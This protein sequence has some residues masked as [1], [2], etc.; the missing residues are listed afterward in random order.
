[1]KAEIKLDINKYIKSYFDLI[2]RCGLNVQPKQKVLISAPVESANLALMAAQAAYDAGAGRVI[3][4]WESRDISRLGFLYTDPE[5][6]ERADPWDKAQLVTLAKEGAAFLFLHSANPEVFSDVNPDVIVKQRRV[7]NASVK[8]WRDRYMSNK[9][10]WCVAAIA[11]ASWARKVF[12][13]LPEEEAIIELWDAIFKAARISVDSSDE[14]LNENLNENLFQNLIENS[15]NA[16]GKHTAELE[17]RCSIL[18]AM[19]LSGLIFKSQ[20]GTKLFVGLPDSHIWQGGREPDVDGV[21]FSPN[22]P[23]EEIFTAPRRDAVNGVVKSS[24]PLVYQ[25]NIID[26]FSLTFRRGKVVKVEAETGRELLTK[27]IR[28]DKNAAYLGEVALVP[29]NSPISQTGLL[30]YETLYDENASCHLAFGES[31]PKCVPGAKGK[32]ASALSRLGINKSTVHVDFMIGTPDMDIVGVKK[33][34]EKIRIF[35]NGNF[36]F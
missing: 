11:G 10:R 33:N 19:N 30:F 4:R 9:N 8:E 35:K 29:N 23:T 18:T 6:F 24:R 1:M 7:F 21:V 34:D 12:P 13:D 36:A 14:N 26:N 17:S 28:S 20:N 2:M 5:E 22:I 16:W 27:I 25:G 3:D 15:N 32:S 31:F